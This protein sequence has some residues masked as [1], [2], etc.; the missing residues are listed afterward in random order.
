LLGF[1]API[2]IYK[3]TELRFHALLSDG[4]RKVRF[5]RAIMRWGL[6]EHHDVPPL[7][8]TLLLVKPTGS[9]WSWVKVRLPS[10]RLE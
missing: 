4:T 10:Q 1:M 9:L 5:R 3:L 7:T 2:P 8:Q 6:H